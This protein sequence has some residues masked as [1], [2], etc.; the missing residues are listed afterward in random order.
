MPAGKR[1]MSVKERITEALC[2]LIEEKKVP[3]QELSIQQIV[4]EAEVCR[5]SFYRNFTSKDDI[6]LKMF[7]KARQEGDVAFRNNPDQTMHGL[8]TSLI[9][10]YRN[11]RRFLLCFYKANPNIYFEHIITTVIQSNTEEKLE[12]ISPAEYYT[13][14]GRAWLP[15]G[16]MTEWIKR[17][18]DL[19]VEELVTL[20]ERWNIISPPGV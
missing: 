8:L 4:S 15:I 16:I 18:C 14:A 13:F 3:Y 10:T 11:N 20:I 1:T 17:D 6:L 12:N 7:E 5:N 2:R 9:E 19:P